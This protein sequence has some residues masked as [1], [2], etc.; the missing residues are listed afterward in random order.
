[1]TKRKEIN[2]KIKDSGVNRKTIVTTMDKANEKITVHKAIFFDITPVISGLFD[3]YA[4]C[5]STSMSKISF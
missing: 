4:D 5:L 1:V 3:A 2:K